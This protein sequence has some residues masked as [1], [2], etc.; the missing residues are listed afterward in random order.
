MLD[1]GRRGS[2]AWQPLVAF[3]GAKSTAP[4]LGRPLGAGPPRHSRKRR[5]L[6]RPRRSRPACRGPGSSTPLPLLVP[7]AEWNH[8]CR[9]PGPAGDAAEPDS[10]RPVRPA[11]AARRRAAAAG[12]GLSQSGL[13]AALPRLAGAARAA[14]CIS[15][16]AIWPAMR[17][18]NWL[19]AGR[20]GPRPDRRGLR[21]REPHRHFADAARRVPRL[22]G[23][24]G[25]RSS[26]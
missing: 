13:S 16:P 12:A 15:T 23:A 2:P 21:D 14:T 24:S 19:V 26:S 6:Q 1:A 7:A 11:A 17:A 10:G 22:P 8:V 25:W 4:T 5:H 9:R 3:A 20:Q 18:G